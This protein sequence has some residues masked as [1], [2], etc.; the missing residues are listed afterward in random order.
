M[1]AEGEWHRAPGSFL[2]FLGSFLGI[3]D[4]FNKNRA[5]SGQKNVFCFLHVA[6]KK[7]KPHFFIY[8]F[9]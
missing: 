7:K 3:L 6:L 4:A 5:K 1:V 2:L 8:F 9:F